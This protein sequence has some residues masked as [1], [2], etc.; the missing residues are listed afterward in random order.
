M[1]AYVNKVA[2]DG[3]ITVYLDGEGTVQFGLYM[4]T[5]L[6]LLGI[7]DNGDRVRFQIEGSE[8]KCCKGFMKN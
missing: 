5:K 1:T 7:N 4:Y 8:Y 3:Y 2:N 6:T